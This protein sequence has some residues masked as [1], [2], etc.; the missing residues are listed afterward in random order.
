[1]PNTCSHVSAAAAL[2]K[3]ASRQTAAT[4]MVLECAIQGDIKLYSTAGGT[5]IVAE[6]LRTP[7]VDELSPSQGLLITNIF[8]LE[9]QAGARVKLKRYGGASFPSQFDSMTR[10]QLYETGYRSN[11]RDIALGVTGLCAIIVSIFVIAVM[12]NSWL[13]GVIGSAIVAAIFAA[14]AAWIGRLT[15]EGKTQQQRWK[16]FVPSHTYGT[17]AAAEQELPIVF[18]VLRGRHIYSWYAEYANVCETFSYR[19][20]WLDGWNGTPEELAPIFS[21]L[22]A[23]FA[24]STAYY[25]NGSTSSTG[26]GC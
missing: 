2:L 1:M 18:V 21:T 13:W 25:G 9:P 17:P 22:T 19:P 4:A 7:D 15:P 6:L 16:T 10:E 26:D 20:A 24:S 23:Y 12:T 8:G 5:E 11:H 14:G 3:V